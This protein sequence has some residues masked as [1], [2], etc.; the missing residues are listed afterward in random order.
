MSIYSHFDSKEV[1][2]RRDL[3]DAEK[4]L[5]INSVVSFK[6]IDE[7]SRVIYSSMNRDTKKLAETIILESDAKDFAFEFKGINNR[8]LIHFQML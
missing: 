4:V 7:T 5:L 1:K 2:T 8:E 6:E 3:I